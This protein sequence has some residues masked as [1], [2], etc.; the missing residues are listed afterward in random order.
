MS[1][2]ENSSVCNGPVISRRVS[3]EAEAE[4]RNWTAGG[5]PPS[6]THPLPTIPP[7]AFHPTLYTTSTTMSLHQ[8]HFHQPQPHFFHNNISP[9]SSPRGSASSARVDFLDTCSATLRPTPQYTSYTDS[10]L[11][12]QHT[13][14][15][16]NWKNSPGLKPLCLGTY[17]HTRAFGELDVDI[18]K[19]SYL[20]SRVG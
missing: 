7:L 16:V 17:T 3:V 2:C 10:A 13:I 14:P 15:S 12:A 20:V 4:L 6:Q 1:A 11:T 5:S 8:Y 18:N 9:S 19:G